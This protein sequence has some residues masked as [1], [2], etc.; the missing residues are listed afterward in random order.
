MQ[1]LLRQECLPVASE[2]ALSRSKLPPQGPP[3]TFGPACGLNP[4]GS[5]SSGQ[6]L[7]LQCN[8]DIL[9]SRDIFS[10]KESSEQMSCEPSSLTWQLWAI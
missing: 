4:Q 9:F 2:T 5:Q 3:P 7:L 8:Q 6:G 1:H 10:R